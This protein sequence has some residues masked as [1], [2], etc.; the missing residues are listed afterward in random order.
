MKE[1]I[2][3]QK[4]VKPIHGYWDGGAKQ[5]FNWSIDGRP[6]KDKNGEFVRVGSWEANQY[7]HVAKGKTD[8]QTLSYAKRHIEKISR[9]PSSFEYVEEEKYGTWRKKKSIKRRK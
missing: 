4:A 1:I 8:K 9:F 5:V 3:R 2:L 7:F 6:H